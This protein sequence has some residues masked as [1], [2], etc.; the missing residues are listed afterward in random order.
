MSVLE[1]LRTV[2]AKYGVNLS[3]AQLGALL[4]EVAWIHKAE[5]VGLERKDSGD[6]AIQPHT[7]IRI[8]HDILRFPGNLGRDVLQDAEGAC[9]VTW[10]DAGPA[11][12]LRFVVPV[13]PDVI[14]PPDDP[15]DDPPASTGDATAALQQQQ[16]VV[17]MQIVAKLDEQIV[18]VKAL[19]E[20][21]KAAIAGGVKIRF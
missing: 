20:S 12:P 14:D 13:Q 5:G 2:R 4:N 6:V 7:G 16:L 10:G 1:T 19:G 3:P 9:N 21:L 18:T 15:P 11:D 17:L 8:G